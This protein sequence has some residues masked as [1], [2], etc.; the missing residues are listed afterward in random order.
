MSETIN[1]KFK[2]LKAS[3]SIKKPHSEDI[4]APQH[5]K[6]PSTP[7]LDSHQSKPYT[8]FIAELISA[9]NSL[10]T[11]SAA[12]T[13]S[14]TLHT[15]FQGADHEAFVDERQKKK[16]VKA[17]QLADPSKV[18]EVISILKAM[19]DP[20]LNATAAKADVPLATEVKKSPSIDRKGT[21]RK[22]E[23]QERQEQL[24][25]ELQEWDTIDKK[26]TWETQK[27]NDQ[28][29]GTVDPESS[30]G[31]FPSTWWFSSAE[32]PS[33][34]PTNTISSNKEDKSNSSSSSTIFGSSWLTTKSKSVTD[35][36]PSKR[37]LSTG[38]Q[39][40]IAA[41]SLLVVAAIAKPKFSKAKTP[42]EDTTK[43]NPP[44]LRSQSSMPIIKSTTL[45]SLI[46]TTKAPSNRKQQ[47][48]SLATFSQSSSALLGT[49]TSITRQL[50]TLN[51]PPP[52]HMI[53]ACT[54]WW[55][56]EIYV[57]HKCMLTIE[58]VTNTG[59]AFFNILSGAIVAIPGMTVLGPI[60]KIIS[61]W[62]GYQWSV[63]KA[64]DLG[65]GV[66]ISATWILPVA[67]ASK[68][69]DHAGN[70]DDPVPENSIPSLRTRKSLK[71][72]LGLGRP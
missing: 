8:T 48:E 38:E 24:D 46:P 44:K 37:S 57:P 21:V 58:R 52:T 36:F 71:L 49:I 59:Q 20:T 6:S 72:K 70:E 66:V 56:Y 28:L 4:F 67:L 16:V 34:I 54:F 64:D 51:G 9:F 55:G 50:L 30:K 61:A 27:S 14:S 25:K 2:T 22:K 53:S 23:K 18:N 65:K 68:P 15:F 33:P 47:A 13:S 42:T 62:V 7:T 31:I 40:A 45:K 63:I 17:L 32:S 11:P 12:P 29:T 41:A 5:L 1:Q 19:P 3:K 39:I 43:A 10:S 35:S 69:W 26:R 60:A